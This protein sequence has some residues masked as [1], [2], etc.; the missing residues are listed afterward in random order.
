[1]DLKSRVAQKV[2]EIALELPRSFSGGD[3][4]LRSVLLQAGVPETEIVEQQTHAHIFVLL[5]FRNK[6]AAEALLSRVRPLKLAGLNVKVKG[7]SPKDWRDNW[8]EA[9][10][11]F[12]LTAKFDVVPLWRKEEYKTTS[13][14]V[15]LIIDTTLSFGTGLHETTRFVAL[16]VEKCEGKFSSFLDVGTGTGIL[17]LVAYHCG[18]RF[19]DMVDVNEDCVAT[20]AKNMARNQAVYHKIFCC[21]ITGF[22]SPTRYDMIV[23]NLTSHDLKR[24][25][26]LLLSLCRA[27]G[28]LAVSGIALE[29]FDDVKEHFKGGALRCVRILK[30]Q[31]WGAL[32]YKKAG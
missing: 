5:Y 1:M 15:P 16:L 13:R 19:I 32:L 7:I 25:A 6:R 23:A 26:P 30:G 27:G 31:S 10:R 28:Y 22:K 21:D 2:I 4:I 12:R 14:R 24:F 18:A 17:S 11:P 29:H 8:K 20:A 9:I 3:E